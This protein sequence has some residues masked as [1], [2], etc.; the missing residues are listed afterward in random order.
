MHDI[1]PNSMSMART[2]ETLTESPQ[3]VLKGPNTSFATAI[4]H[5]PPKTNQTTTKRKEGRFRREIGSHLFRSM[6][7]ERFASLL[8]IRNPST[9]P[10][11][12]F[13]SSGPYSV[14]TVASSSQGSSGKHAQVTVRRDHLVCEI[15]SHSSS[16]STSRRS[17]TSVGEQPWRRDL[18]YVHE[19]KLSV[20]NIFQAYPK[21]TSFIV[22]TFY[23]LI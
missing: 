16:P 21:Y 17:A 22:D 1:C 23:L 11:P 2:K 3:G 6:T 4:L 8:G 7:R 19:L 5:D 14:S 15:A 9:P 10:K 18:Y 13:S 12:I 20:D